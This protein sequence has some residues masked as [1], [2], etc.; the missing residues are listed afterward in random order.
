MIKFIRLIFLNFL[1]LLFSSDLS[2]QSPDLK[3][4]ISEYEGGGAV[5]TTEEA[6]RE[7][8]RRE[9]IKMMKRKLKRLI[10]IVNG[11]IPNK[12]IKSFKC[13]DDVMLFYEI[14]SREVKAYNSY[15]IDEDLYCWEA[16][17]LKKKRIKPGVITKVKEYK[18]FY[19]SAL[20]E[21]IKG[22][23]NKDDIW[24]FSDDIADNY[25]E[26][27]YEFTVDYL[28]AI[29]VTPE[30]ANVLVE[31]FNDPEVV[32]GF[33]N[34]YYKK[35]SDAGGDILK[36]FGILAGGG[37]G[38]LTLASIAE[39]EINEKFGK[40]KCY[41]DNTIMGL[42]EL[43]NEERRKHI[44][45]ITKLDGAYKA[46]EDLYRK[47]RVL[48]SR[49]WYLK[50]GSGKREDDLE[51][52]LDKEFESDFSFLNPIIFINYAMRVKAADMR[53]DTPIA[54]RQASVTC[55]TEYR[56]LVDTFASKSGLPCARGFDT[57]MPEFPIAVKPILFRGDTIYN[58]FGEMIG[59][60]EK[61]TTK[62]YWANYIYEIYY[63][64]NEKKVKIDWNERNC[65]IGYL[66]TM[67]A[68]MGRC[69][70]CPIFAGIIDTVSNATHLVYDNLAKTAYI[71]LIIG[72]G[73]WI[74]WYFWKNYFSKLEIPNDSKTIMHEFYIK[75]G[76]AFLVAAL[77]YAGQPTF[78]F[79]YLIEPVINISIGY[80]YDFLSADTDTD[81]QIK[82]MTYSEKKEFEKATETEYQGVVYEDFMNNCS[83]TEI[84]LETGYSGLI[85]EKEY[86][87][88]VTDEYR[89]QQEKFGKDVKERVPLISFD[90][91]ENLLCILHAIHL[92]NARQ[93]VIGTVVIQKG[94]MEKW[95]FVI[96]NFRLVFTGLMIYIVFFLVNLSFPLLFAYNFVEIIIIAVL[97]PIYGL[98]WVIDEFGYFSFKDSNIKQ[99]IIDAGLS[100]AMVTIAITVCAGFLNAYMMVGNEYGDV[101]ARYVVE[102]AFELDSPKMLAEVF[103]MEQIGFFEIMFIG[104]I[105]LYILK[106]IPQFMQDFM[107]GS[108]K[109]DVFDTARSAVGA[110]ASRV[111]DVTMNA[112]RTVAQGKLENRNQ[113]KADAYD[114]W[115][116][117]RGYSIT[118]K[119]G[120]K[121]GQPNTIKGVITAQDISYYLKTKKVG[122]F[123]SMRRY[124]KGKQSRFRI[125]I[126]PNA[127]SLYDM[128]NRPIAEI[129]YIGTY[130]GKIRIDNKRVRKITINVVPK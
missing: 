75:F 123:V 106:N 23:I 116:R 32:Q 82:R 127:I 107:P 112:A 26:Y 62:G 40:Q 115:L 86:N 54:V 81:E 10:D 74:P 102:L 66:R 103:S 28:R 13:S 43:E 16:A 42:L 7:E 44:D 68:E 27:I 15:M 31:Y 36:M 3:Y 125:K 118:L 56:P 93:M 59:K 12:M 128:S 72:L 25:E 71:L 33:I 91:R 30:K 11:A 119:R 46:I 22:F 108:M 80:S 48:F 70:S 21:S 41:L 47:Y 98:T 99:K 113:F 84:L 49:D 29:G 95:W 19:S 8:M 55:D 64:F 67:L 6:R 97:I 24:I 60:V 52:E 37:V 100:I 5:Y 89:A 88:G 69:W 57:K 73:I 58:L 65:G 76:K 110:I 126:P 51:T 124:N 20:K 18:K 96:P 34:Q 104:L 1:L 105:F 4:G 130:K 63:P 122:G 111:K 117:S 90:T 120:T 53:S 50:S 83:S 14:N 35:F 92:K 17:Y 38:I 45:Q 79:R 87:T 114:N 39:D 121:R 61:D 77:I 78:I 2:A 85:N 109:T 9:K 101:G 129:R 94:F